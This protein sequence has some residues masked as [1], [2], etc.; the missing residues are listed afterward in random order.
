VITERILG[1]LYE[2]KEYQNAMNEAKA[3]FE[4]WERNK[5]TNRKITKD[6]FKAQRLAK[7]DMEKLGVLF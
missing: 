4:A 2:G 1:G 5:R 6:K 3:E 7:L